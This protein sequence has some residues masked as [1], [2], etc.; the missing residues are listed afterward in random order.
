[1][2][3]RITRSMGEDVLNLDTAEARRK[4]SVGTPAGSS[5]SGASASGN[6]A[7]SAPAQEEPEPKTPSEDENES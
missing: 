3:S 2:M 7:S 6:S 4:A 1:M 5:A